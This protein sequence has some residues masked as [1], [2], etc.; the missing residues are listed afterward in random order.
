MANGIVL[1]L[2]V[3]DD[4]FLSPGIEIFISLCAM[5]IYLLDHAIYLL[6]I[7]VYLLSIVVLMGIA[8]L[9]LGISILMLGRAILHIAIVVLKIGIVVGLLVSPQVYLIIVLVG[10]KISNLYPS[11]EMAPALEVDANWTMPEPFIGAKRM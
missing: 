8:S 4:V 1:C 11:A 3:A 2:V 6:I 9:M 10:G 7:A 5:A